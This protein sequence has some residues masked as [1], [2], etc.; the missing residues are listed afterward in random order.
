MKNK[1]ESAKNS[2]RDEHTPTPIS[3]AETRLT[4][5]EHN[6]LT[7]LPEQDK[8]QIGGLADTISI[9]LPRLAVIPS[10]ARN[11]TLGASVTPVSLCDLSSGGRSLIPPWRD[12]G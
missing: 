6:G 7:P 3:L 11:L 5:S 10:G 8:A 2:Q 4:I 9:S 12:S 1:K